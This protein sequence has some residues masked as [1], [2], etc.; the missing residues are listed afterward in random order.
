[1]AA[2]KL[3]EEKLKH[4]VDKIRRAVLTERLGITTFLESHLTFEW[5]IGNGRRGTLTTENSALPTPETLQELGLH[6]PRARHSF[7]GFDG[8]RVRCEERVHLLVTYE[9]ARVDACSVILGLYSDPDYGIAWDGSLDGRPVG[10][11]EFEFILFFSKPG[12]FDFRVQY[13]TRDGVVGGQRLNVI[14]E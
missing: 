14:V 11:N 9:D 13:T 5:S 10:E 7:S 1:M 6:R 4:K 12:A 3:E 8:D 2:V